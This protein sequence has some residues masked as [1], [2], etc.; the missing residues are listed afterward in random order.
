MAVSFLESGR[1]KRILCS[2][3]VGAV[4]FVEHVKPNGAVVKSYCKC[5]KVGFKCSGF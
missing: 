4:V 5:F 2:K 3:G 1:R